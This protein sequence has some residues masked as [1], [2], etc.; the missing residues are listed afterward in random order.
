MR[1]TYDRES[2]LLRFL[3]CPESSS[4]PHRRLP[5]SLS[6]NVSSSFGSAPTSSNRSKWGPTSTSSPTYPDVE[7]F[8]SILFPCLYHL[9]CL[10]SSDLFRTLCPSSELPHSASSTSQSPGISSS[11]TIQCCPTWQRVSPSCPEG[12]LAIGMLVLGRRSDAPP[13]WSHHD[14]WVSTYFEIRRLG[15]RHSC[16]LS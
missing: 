10:R 9:P 4:V 7:D 13:W 6:G 15:L 2:R 5:L 11:L 16:S 8:W 12:I 3:F 1:S 14:T